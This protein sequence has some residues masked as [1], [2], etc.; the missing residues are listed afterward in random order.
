MNFDGLKIPP[1]AKIRRG[2]SYPFGGFW[3]LTHR[4]HK[5]FSLCVFVNEGRWEVFVAP[6]LPKYNGGWC[7]AACGFA[8]GQIASDGRNLRLE[9]I[10]GERKRFLHI[11]ADGNVVV[12]AADGKILWA[13][14]QTDTI[15]VGEHFAADG[16]FCPIPHFDG[17][18]EQFGA[19]LA[20]GLK[21]YQK[22]RDSFLLRRLRAQLRQRIKRT[23]RT[24]AAVQKDREKLGDPQKLSRLADTIMANL[25]R[26]PPHAA[27]AEMVDPYTGEK[28]TVQLDPAV[29]PV[30]YAEKLYARARKAR[31]GAEIIARRLEELAAE[32]ESLRRLENET[33]Y[34]KIAE[35]LEI[36]PTT[37]LGTPESEVAHKT[38]PKTY[39]AGIKRFV[40][41]DGFEI[42]VGRNASANNRLTFE[43]AAKD[44]I[45]LHAEGVSGAHTII[46]VAGR[47]DV[48]KRTIEQAA[49][50]AAFYSDAKHSSLAPVIYTRRRYVHPVRGKPGLVRLDRGETIF[51]KPAEKI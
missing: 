8:I 49:A 41:A 34:R 32:L 40:S 20:E 45:W 9:L 4:R 10:S 48:P 2:Y 24:I 43:I 1:M 6:P 28:I 25:Y 26:I 18:K 11:T 31:Q 5:K 16:E 13:H 50:L 35:A 19:L 36:D 15:K 44:D 22:I 29:P 39:G 21:K 33:D 12:T 47:K 51:V 37:F 42:L 38:Q 3:E 23:E 7:S 14:R 27:E 17:D 46:R 30:R